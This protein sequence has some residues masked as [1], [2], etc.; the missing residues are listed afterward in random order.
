MAL[1]ELFYAGL[2][3]A[4]GVEPDLGLDKLGRASTT[5]DPPHM[6]HSSTAPL[7]KAAQLPPQPGTVHI[8]LVNFCFVRYSRLH[9][10]TNEGCPI[11]FTTRGGGGGGG[12]WAPHILSPFIIWYSRVGWASISP[13]LKAA[14]LPSQPG[15]PPHMSCHH[16]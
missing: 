5:R 3:P 14:Q 13:L 16:L 1:Y 15:G 4:L 9:S 2:T 10:S 6:S 8:C 11:A 12:G 7:L